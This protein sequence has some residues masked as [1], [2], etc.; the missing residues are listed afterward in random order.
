MART[1]TNAELFDRVKTVYVGRTPDSP[2]GDTTT[3]TALSDGDTT[4]SVAD[5]TGFSDGDYVRIHKNED[6]EFHEVASTSSGQ[7]TLVSPIAFDHDSGVVVK[8]QERVELGEVTDD[9]INVEG[10]PTRNEITVATQKRP[11]AWLLQMMGR[12]MTFDLENYNLENLALALGIDEGNITG[13]GTASD[14]H[15][16]HENA[17]DMM[18]DNQRTLIFEGALKDGTIVEV[19]GFHAR[20]DPTR[21]LNLVSGQGVPVPFSADVHHVM[22]LQWT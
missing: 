16:L 2:S 3:D 17:A 9:G 4:V 10:N 19:R 5:E 8:S 1:L 6:L 18:A 14:P 13:S 21:T 7:I 11:Y 20:M 22:Q 12:Q 15:V